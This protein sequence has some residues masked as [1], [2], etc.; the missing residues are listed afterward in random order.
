MGQLTI[1]LY[2]SGKIHDIVKPPKETQSEPSNSSMDFFYF[3]RFSLFHN[4]EFKISQ[5][6]T[7]G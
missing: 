1:G 4:L 7:T 3:A 6:S 2:R 5:Y